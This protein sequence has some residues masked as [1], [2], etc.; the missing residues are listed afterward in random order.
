[1]TDDLRHFRPRKPLAPWQLALGGAFILVA[2]GIAGS[3]D[4]QDAVNARAEAQ[5]QMPLLMHPL[6]GPDCQATITQR[7]YGKWSPEKCAK[8]KYV[9][10]R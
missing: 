10:A 8:A 3:M 2:Y 4:Y 6:R 9:R 7:S 1:M 5:A